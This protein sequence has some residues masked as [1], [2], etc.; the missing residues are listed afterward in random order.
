MNCPLVILL[1]SVKVAEVRQ[2]HAA[3][4]MGLRGVRADFE[5]GVVAAN[6]LGIAAQLVQGLATIGVGIGVGGLER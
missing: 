5:S 2:R 6:C 3:V 1:R 4:V